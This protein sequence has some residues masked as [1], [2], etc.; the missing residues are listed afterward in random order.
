[1]GVHL[2]PYFSAEG[3]S[4]VR[5]LFLLFQLK[6]VQLSYIL[7]STFQNS[8]SQTKSLKARIGCQYI[9]PSSATN[10]LNL[11]TSVTLR[12]SIQDC[13][14][15]GAICVKTITQKPPKKITQKP[16]AGLMGICGMWNYTKNSE[17][18]PVITQNTCTGGRV[19]S[20]HHKVFTGEIS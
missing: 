19:R 14:M 5:S 17:K 18:K 11:V 3:E 9:L 13:C 7:P 20:L 16:P 4:C 8:V 1:M 12:Y 6:E 2:F 10:P 15:G